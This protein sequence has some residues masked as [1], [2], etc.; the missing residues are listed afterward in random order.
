[1][2]DLITSLVSSLGIG[3]VLVWYLYYNVSVVL[4]KKDEHF[5]AA[6]DQITERFTATLREEREFRATEMQRLEHMFERSECRY[7]QGK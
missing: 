4:P 7:Q 2:E 6:V 3:G 5:R 1:M